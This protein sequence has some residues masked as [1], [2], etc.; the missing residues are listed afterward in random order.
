MS[1]VFRSYQNSNQRSD[2]SARDRMRHRDKIKQS[3]RDNIGSIIADE[4]IIGK[5]KNKIIKVPLRSIKEYRFVYGD[6]SPDAAQGNGKVKPGD[7]VGKGKQEADGPGQG[8][9]NEKGNDALETE[10]SL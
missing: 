5:S 10:V 1:S 3:I 7:V 6:N 9:G 4:S 8:A 2:R